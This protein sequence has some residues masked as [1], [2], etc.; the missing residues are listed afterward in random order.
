MWNLKYDRNKIEADSQTQRRDSWLL[1]KKG[2]G[3]KWTGSV[4]LAGENYNIENG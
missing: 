4:G 3:G 1:S 2:V